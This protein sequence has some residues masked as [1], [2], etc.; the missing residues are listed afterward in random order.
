[1]NGFVNVPMLSECCNQSPELAEVNKLDFTL[2]TAN[3]C[4]LKVLPS[5]HCMLLELS[6][7]QLQPQ[8]FP[9]LHF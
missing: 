7:I 8:P 9:S 1:M 2:D 5:V 6:H 4:P 3:Q